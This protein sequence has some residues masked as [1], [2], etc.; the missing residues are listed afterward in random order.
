MEN[1]L[2]KKISD[3]SRIGISDNDLE[4]L[5]EFMTE[6]IEYTKQLDIEAQKYKDKSIDIF[7]NCRFNIFRKDICKDTKAI[8]NKFLSNAPD[9]TESHFI[10]PS[11]FEKGE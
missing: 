4:T 6:V 1:K 3:L 9:K 8:K 11:L 10:V 7:E 5:N 2:I